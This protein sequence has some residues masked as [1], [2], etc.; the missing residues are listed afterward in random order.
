MANG[1]HGRDGLPKHTT[2]TW[3]VELLIS[4]VAVFAMLQLPGWLDDGMF[5]L[6]PRLGAAW[7]EVTEA[8]TEEF[9]RN[10]MHELARF[11][12]RVLTVLPRED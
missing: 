3:E 10:Y 11:I 7:G 8:S 12:E 4:G 5:A 9:L 6:A 2:P 1:E